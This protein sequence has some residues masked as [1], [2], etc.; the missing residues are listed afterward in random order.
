MTT[1]IQL[2]FQRNFCELKLNR[3]LRYTLKAKIM[4][5]EQAE[6]RQA[7]KINSFEHTTFKLGAD[8]VRE[9]EGP[10]SA[11]T[12]VIEFSIDEDETKKEMII[13][14]TPG[15][16][17][18]FESNEYKDRFFYKFIATAYSRDR[19]YIFGVVENPSKIVVI[20]LSE[21][22]HPVLSGHPIAQNNIKS[23]FYFENS[24][25]LIVVGD[26][27]RCYGVNYDTFSIY[28]DKIFADELLHGYPITADFESE[29]VYLPTRDGY[30]AY[31]LNGIR[32]RKSPFLDSLNHF[33]EDFYDCMIYDSE[34]LLM[35]HNNLSLY[36]LNI[37]TK[38]N[39]ELI[40]SNEKANKL[41]K[42][43]TTRIALSFEGKIT[44]YE[45]SV[46]WKTWIA[47]GINPV[48]IIRYNKLDSAARILT[49]GQNST[50]I[51][52]SPR[53]G[54]EIAKIE[55]PNE[56]IDVSARSSPGPTQYFYDRGFFIYKSYLGAQST[57]AY[58]VK[59]T[60]QRD[61][62]FMISKEGF[63][64]IYNTNIWP[65]K[66]IAWKNV[67]AVSM[68]ICK[69]E[70]T[71]YYIVS[72]LKNELLLMNTHNFEFVHKFEVTG[73]PIL[74]ID[75]YFPTNLVLLVREQ[76]LTFY[77]LKKDWP[78]SRTTVCKF[79][80]MKMNADLI[81]LGFSSGAIERISMNNRSLRSKE[82]AKVHDA[83]V[84]DFAFSDTFWVSAAAD[85]SIYVWNYTINAI[86]TRIILPV[87]I[88]CLSVINGHKSV[89]VGIEN[90]VMLLDKKVFSG[91]SDKIKKSDKIHKSVDSHDTIKDRFVPISSDDPIRPSDY[92]VYPLSSKTQTEF[93]ISIN[94][95]RPS[96]FPHEVHPP[97]SPK[98]AK[99]ARTNRPKVDLFGDSDRLS[100]GDN[101]NDNS[102]LDFHE[103]TNAE[104]MNS[105]LY[106]NNDLSN[107]YNYDYENDTEVDSNETGDSR[108]NS[109]KY[110]NGGASSQKIDFNKPM[111]IPT[112]LYPKTHRMITSPLITDASGFSY[113]HDDDVF[114]NTQPYTPMD[115]EMKAFANDADSDSDDEDQFF[116]SK[117]PAKLRSTM[118][119][120]SKQPKKT[121]PYFAIS[122]DLYTTTVPKLP[123]RVSLVVPKAETPR[124]PHLNDT[125]MFYAH[126]YLKRLSQAKM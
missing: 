41:F 62:F 79:T 86:F 51:F 6:L 57:H 120:E 99:S 9:I 98:I 24:K 100:F 115:R 106:N 112:G 102:K 67:G 66:E 119:I 70:K 29:A 114:V 105:D 75:Y 14:T 39:I 34:H 126:L 15:D 19:N 109:G 80:C 25:M 116:K 45:L 101:M 87:P 22:G 103:I 121:I 12:G 4:T 48:S 49:Q 89:A 2:F 8:P 3:F 30:S 52:T 123:P 95:F 117:F 47:A 21:V 20:D 93:P 55:S 63:I 122:T 58:R 37:K 90:A 124:K 73:P 60:T 94:T 27:V 38:K 83:P 64:T 40:H 77:D 35:L 36:L 118:Y 76:E 23:I 10:Y 54:L 28:L 26:S 5:Y 108:S 125:D 74:K 72:T 33:A 11:A 59:Y 31:D 84:T 111:N 78:I 42:A 65:F 18:R 7:S 43:D 104:Q 16:F 1:S 92:V 46:F 68:S 82:K 71:W 85:G 17:F 113:N 91:Q 53:D 107:T 56:F 88:R 32:A 110:T 61:R 97:K 69:Y 81:Y 44:F 96:T 50:V 13:I